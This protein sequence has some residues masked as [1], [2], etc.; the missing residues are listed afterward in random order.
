MF[1][2]FTRASPDNSIRTLMG[3][4]VFDPLQL[5]TARPMAPKPGFNCG[6]FTNYNPSHQNSAAMTWGCPARPPIT[7][8]STTASIFMFRQLRGALRASCVM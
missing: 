6:R 4:T 5:L 8:V 3:V 7:S 1:E 2:V